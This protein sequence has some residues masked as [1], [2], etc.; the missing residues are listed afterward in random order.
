MST[1]TTT[2]IEN[3]IINFYVYTDGGA[4]KWNEGGREVVVSNIPYSVVRTCE[5]RRRDNCSTT[6][7]RSDRYTKTTSRDILVNI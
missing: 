3:G 6:V 4:R 7:R 1:T 5:R 2:G